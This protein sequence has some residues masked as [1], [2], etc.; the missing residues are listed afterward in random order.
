MPAKFPEL[1]WGSWWEIM[2]DLNLEHHWALDVNM[3]SSRMVEVESLCPA[4]L[5]AEPFTHPVLPLTFWQGPPKPRRRTRQRQGGVGSRDAP[6]SDASEEEGGEEGED[7]GGGALD[8]EDELFDPLAD[9]IALLEELGDVAPPPDESSSSD[10]EILAGVGY[11]PPPKAHAA[12]PVPT[13]FPKASVGGSSSST[14]GMAPAPALAP[15]AAPLPP[16]PP[17]PDPPPPEG[18]APR[19]PRNFLRGRFPTVM[20]PLGNGYLRRSKG[21]NTLPDDF[22]DLRAVCWQHN[23]CTLSRSCA[24]NDRSPADGRPAGVLWRYLQV[25]HRYTDKHTHKEAMLE[26]SEWEDRR[27]ARTELTAMPDWNLNW[28]VAER[29]GRGAELDEEPVGL[30]G[31]LTPEAK[32]LQRVLSS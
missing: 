6:E 30:A 12:P 27:S 29:P 8:E 25:A 20:C 17:P 28:Q 9:A 10:D 24:P 22:E 26:W 23:T 1:Y 21:V 11:P 16:L 32:A 14:A 4:L 2:R 15:A 18:P 7:G 3:L 31:G 5:I 13:A 19:R